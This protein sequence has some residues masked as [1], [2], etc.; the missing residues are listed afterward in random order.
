MVAM[1][2]YH[3][4]FSRFR[5]YDFHLLFHAQN[6]R[7]YYGTGLICLIVSYYTGWCIFQSLRSLSINVSTT[8]ASLEVD[9]YAGATDNPYP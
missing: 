9:G 7:E 2:C 6:C 3:I 5:K 8:M 1:Q 4:K